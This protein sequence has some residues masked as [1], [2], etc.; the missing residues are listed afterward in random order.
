MNCTGKNLAAQILEEAREFGASLAGIASV[1]E[2]KTAPSFVVAPQMPSYSGVGHK[3]A[4]QD[5]KKPSEV[6][7]SPEAKSIVVIAY[8]H[9]DNQPELDY[10]YG[11]DSPSGNKK[12]IAIANAL[13]TWLQETHGVNALNLPYH[14]EK[15]GIYLKDAAVLAGLGCVGRNNLLL[16]PEYG[17]R[18]RLRALSVGI[19][20]PPTGPLV[21]DPCSDCDAECIANCPQQAFARQL[22]K[23]AE[24]GREELPGRS[25]NYSRIACNTQMNADETDATQETV[26]GMAEPASIIKYCRRCELFC[27]VGRP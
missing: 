12:L 13:C 21:F 20:L 18:V 16:T 8:H 24:F 10:W 26:A 19:D 2:L 27:P 4:P 15:G 3:T 14:T 25:G 9:P 22:Y 7:W 6:T 11:K 5:G 23:A 17:S 1:E